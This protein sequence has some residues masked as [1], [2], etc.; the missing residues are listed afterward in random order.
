MT[1]VLQG[2]VSELS[3]GCHVINRSYVINRSSFLYIFKWTISP[4]KLNAAPLVM[5]LLS[6]QTFDRMVDSLIS[7]S[8]SYNGEDWV[9]ELFVMKLKMWVKF[10]VIRI[11]KVNLITD[12]CCCGL[13]MQGVWCNIGM[14]FFCWRWSC[15]I[16]QCWCWLRRMSTKK[17]LG[18]VFA[19]IFMQSGMQKEILQ[20]TDRRGHREL[21]PWTGG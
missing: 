7:P 9:H 16:N 12:H 20:H 18:R 8:T 14:T 3:M 17:H 1:F 10:F 13:A 5:K 4:L 2:L 21:T 6:F 19:G 11:E 15:W